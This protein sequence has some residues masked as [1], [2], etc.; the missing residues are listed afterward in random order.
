MQ[1]STQTW[2]IITPLRQD[3]SKGIVLTIFH[4]EV[5]TFKGGP[6]EELGGRKVVSRR[7]A[8][9]QRG[10][11]SRRDIVRSKHWLKWWLTQTKWVFAWFSLNAAKV[12]Q[13][14]NF[15]LIPSSKFSTFG[16]LSQT[17]SVL[18]LSGK[19][20]LITWT[21]CIAPFSRSKTQTTN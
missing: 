13:K 8:A 2:S 6:E 18:L 15:T 10:R 11:K 21:A 17:W 14:K 7:R 1:I 4:Y 3:Y 12:F 19:L 5:S 9:L 20:I 16:D